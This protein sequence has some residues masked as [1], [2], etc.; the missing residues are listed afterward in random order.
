M[1]K[2]EK[3]SRRRKEAHAK[4]Q[5]LKSKIYQAFLHVEESSVLGRCV[6]EEDQRAHCV[7]PSKPTASRACNGTSINARSPRSR[8]GRN[9]NGR[10]PCDGVCPLR[11]RG[12][13]ACP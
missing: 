3:I 5:S 2:I 11:S 12:N 4:L 13:G 9:R 10:G 6:T 1:D 7:S 8:R